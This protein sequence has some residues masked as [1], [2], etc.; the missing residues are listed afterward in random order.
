M[1]CY[2]PREKA[3]E[4]DEDDLEDDERGDVDGHP[5]GVPRLQHLTHLAQPHI[6]PFFGSSGGGL[7]PRLMR[8]LVQRAPQVSAYWSVPAIPLFGFRVPTGFP[9]ILFSVASMGKSS[10]G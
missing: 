7:T 9:K 6:D 5:P 1:G 10:Y 4:D 3:K 8:S 2:I